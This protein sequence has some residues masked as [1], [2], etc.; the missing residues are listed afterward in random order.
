MAIS[1]IYQPIELKC[2]SI[3]QLDPSASH[4][5]IS[6]LRA[7]QGEKLIVFNGSG[8]EYKGTITE[9]SKKQISL[10]VEEHILRDVE[11]PLELYLAQGI[12]RG[13]KMDYTIQKAVELGVKKIIPLFTERCTIKL[14]PERRNR[15]SQHWQSIIVSACEQSGRNKLPELLPPM[16]LEEGLR[17]IQADWRFV[18]APTAASSLKEKKI[19]KNQRVILLI[20]PEGGL[21]EQ[22]ISQAS[23]HGFIPLKLGPRILRT[24]TAAVAA[25]TALQCTFG[26]ME[27]V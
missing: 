15:R 27:G 13:E 2:D 19:L 11:S 24:E 18:L 21:S 23:K 20:G 9:I 3:V 14:D 5:I 1:R 12:S 26:D 25:L 16:T 7:K 10:R 22:E 17:S 4:K 8:S 6:V